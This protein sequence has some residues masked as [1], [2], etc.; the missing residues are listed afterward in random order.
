MG[1]GIALG[2]PHALGSEPIDVEREDFLLAVTAEMSKAEI[3]G[4]D[5]DDVG[6]GGGGMCLRDEQQ[7]DRADNGGEANHV[8]F[9]KWC[10]VSDEQYASGRSVCSEA[11]WGSFAKK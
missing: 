2:K 3:V 5:E 10:A 7:E 11:V 9:I 4:H 8:H 6:R 1:A